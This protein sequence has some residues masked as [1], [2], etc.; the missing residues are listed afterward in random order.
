MFGIPELVLI[1]LIIA[2]LFGR[3]LPKLGSALGET[4]R[5]FR[6]ER[7]DDEKPVPPARA[8]MASREAHISGAGQSGMMGR[9]MS[10]CW[11]LVRWFWRRGG[12]R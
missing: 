4:V 2:V 10:L 8:A 6:R 5:A 7:G 11:R 3:R 12:G 9:I 1:L